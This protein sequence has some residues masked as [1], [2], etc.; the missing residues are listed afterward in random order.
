MRFALQYDAATSMT[1]REAQD[2]NEGNT[3]NVHSADLKFRTAPL[4]ICYDYRSRSLL[5]SVLRRCTHLCLTSAL[6]W[7][8]ATLAF[9][10]AAP[11]AAS[12]TTLA[13]A[14]QAVPSAAYVGKRCFGDFIWP[15]HFLRCCIGVLHMWEPRAYIARL[16]HAGRAGQHC[17][18]RFCR[19]R[20]L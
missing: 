11:P 1:H 14:H 8:T 10:S 9:A 6:R 20:R 4:N 15:S 7:D 3:N 2:L 13:P 12:R 16:P 18:H 19:T 17:W 5:P